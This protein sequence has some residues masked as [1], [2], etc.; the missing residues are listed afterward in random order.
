[1]G[2]IR[3]Q[4]VEQAGEAPCFN[5]IFI[6]IPQG[7]DMLSILLDAQDDPLLH[8]NVSKITCTLALNLMQWLS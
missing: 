1:M 7:L 5:L 3:G 8:L 2:G 4:K 6:F